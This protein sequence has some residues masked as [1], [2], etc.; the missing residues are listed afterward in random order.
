MN[1]INKNIFLKAKKNKKALFF[2]KLINQS[3]D[4]NS[5]IKA[6][7][8]KFNLD[9]DNQ[10]DKFIKNNKGQSTDIYLNNNLD[11]QFWYAAQRKDLIN[12]GG[13]LPYLPEIKDFINT[14]NPVLGNSPWFIKG[15]INFVGNDGNL[16]VHNDGQDVI[17]WTC[18]GEV[19]YRIYENFEPDS[20]GNLNPT[21]KEYTS[22]MMNPGDVI[23]MPAGVIHHAILKEPRA[24]LIL[25]FYMEE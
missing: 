7:N 3:P 10:N 12:N 25:D 21:G 17:S 14:I 13:C 8:Y 5:F 1:K 15:L 19:E 24:S 6:L 9:K 2:P 16:N 22:Y 20:D 4:W 11:P 23:F 18:I